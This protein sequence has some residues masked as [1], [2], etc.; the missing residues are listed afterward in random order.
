MN[1]NTS[2]K[3]QVD[4]DNEPYIHGDITVN[5][6]LIQWTNKNEPHCKKTYVVDSQYVSQKDQDIL[7]SIERNSKTWGSLKEY[8]SFYYLGKRLGQYVDEI[9]NLIDTREL[10]FPDELFSDER[11]NVPNQEQQEEIMEEILQEYISNEYYAPD[12]I[13]CDMTIKK[14]SKTLLNGFGLIIYADYK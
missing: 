4:K 8:Y 6:Y 2:L 14:T 12:P 13:W 7:L 10:E 3:I 1:K 5:Y 11:L 9:E